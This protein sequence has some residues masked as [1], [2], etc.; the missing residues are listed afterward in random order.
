[1]NNENQKNNLGEK[2]EEYL[3][4]LPSVNTKFYSFTYC[5]VEIIGVL[6]FLILFSVMS[7]FSF[8]SE[9]PNLAISICFFIAVI[10]LL[11]KLIFSIKKLIRVFKEKYPSSRGIKLSD[12]GYGILGIGFIGVFIVISISLTSAIFNNTALDEKL[13][14]NAIKIIVPIFLVGAIVYNIGMMTGITIN[15]KK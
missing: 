14:S 6:F 1:M 10:L 15:K 5:I 2:V 11:I 8:K 7:I 9:D 3:D 13:L 4:S 12:I